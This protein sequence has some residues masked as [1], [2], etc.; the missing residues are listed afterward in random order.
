MTVFKFNLFVYT[1]S[2]NDLNLDQFNSLPKP[3]AYSTP[4]DKLGSEAVYR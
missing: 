3:G 4:A 1:T 2:T